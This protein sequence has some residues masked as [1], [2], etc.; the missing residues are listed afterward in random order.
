MKN[1]LI[2]VNETELD[3]KREKIIKEG[4]G[5]FHVL[6]DFDRTLTKAF[7]NGEKTPSVISILRNEDYLSEEYSKKAK[8]LAEKYHP[9]EMNLNISVEERKKAM[10]EWWSSHFELLINS[11]LNKKHIEKVV[12]SEKI[13]LRGGAPEFLDFLNEKNIPLIIFSSAGLGGDSISLYLEKQNLLSD[14]IHIVSNEFEWNDDG[15][16]IGIKEPIIHVMNKDETTIQKYPVFEFIKNKRNVLLLGDSL[17]DVGMIKGFDYDTLIKV[18][19]L[20]ENE[21]ENLE[22]Y[23]TN[24]D[25]VILNDGNFDFVNEI[26]G[27]IK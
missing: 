11:G 22:N 21:G 6:A 3:K 5:K 16:A 26:L 8:E 13:K 1:N 9:I 4:K 12:E 25:A 18:G 2:I 17:G 27:D 23:K 20:N 14:N 24:F 7:V 19:F 15:K 10:N